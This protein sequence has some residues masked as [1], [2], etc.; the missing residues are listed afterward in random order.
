M[1]EA[2]PKEL[3][4]ILYSGDNDVNNALSEKTKNSSNTREIISFTMLVPW[5]VTTNVDAF[6]DFNCST[7]LNKSSKSYDF[8]R[9]DRTSINDLY[10]LVDITSV[11]S[12]LYR[13]LHYF[14]LPNDVMLHLI[15]L[16]LN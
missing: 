11:E 3:D 7:S 13:I 12:I 10:L 8:D 9:E 4:L 14:D 5:T 16:Q 2:L 1:V 15:H 6:G